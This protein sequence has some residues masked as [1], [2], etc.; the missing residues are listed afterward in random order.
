MPFFLK[1]IYSL[2]D[3]YMGISVRHLKSI[4]TRRLKIVCIYKKKTRHS[5]HLSDKANKQ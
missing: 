4:K 2:T 5:Y 1:H 3:G